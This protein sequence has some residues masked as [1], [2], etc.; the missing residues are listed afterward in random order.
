MT[1]EGGFT[2]PHSHPRVT[3]RFNNCCSFITR[4]QVFVNPIGGQR[5]GVKRWESVSPIFARAG[6]ETEVVLTQRQNH[7][8][9]VMD[10][11]SDEDL[12]ARDGVVVVVSPESHDNKK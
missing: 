10:E 1:L 3:T 5:D 12:L 6:V 8:F 2:L 9:D 7:A 4:G 11:A